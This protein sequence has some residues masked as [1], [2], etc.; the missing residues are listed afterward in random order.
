MIR[1]NRHI[2]LKLHLNSKMSRSASYQTKRKGYKQMINLKLR[3]KV[4]LVVAQFFEMTVY[5]YYKKVYKNK[6]PY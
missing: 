1:S 2:L 6:N 4:T 3:R 5:V